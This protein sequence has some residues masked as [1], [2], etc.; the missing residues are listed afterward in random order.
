M[1]LS[2]TYLDIFCQLLLLD[3][4]RI[5][6][7]QIMLSQ[8]GVLNVIM[9]YIHENICL[10]VRLDNLCQMLYVQSKK[11]DSLLVRARIHQ[12]YI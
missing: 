1:Y 10:T 8:F 6:V 5:T 2:K 9:K 3:I 12:F 4:Q 11:A 7:Y